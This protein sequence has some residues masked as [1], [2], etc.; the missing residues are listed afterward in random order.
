MT[1]YLP[2]PGI[3]TLDNSFVLF[4]NIKTDEFG[5]WVLQEIPENIADA[6]PPIIIVS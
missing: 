3:L 4:S 6:P 5:K 2:P 1:L